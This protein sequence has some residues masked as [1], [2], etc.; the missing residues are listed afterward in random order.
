MRGRGGFV[1][2]RDV[3]LCLPKISYALPTT[4]YN[5]KM[6]AFV[7]LSKFIGTFLEPEGK[8]HFQTDLEI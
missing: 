8:G 6:I 1:R 7:V 2:E 5:I 3:G 4:E